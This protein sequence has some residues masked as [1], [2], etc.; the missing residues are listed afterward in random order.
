MRL[1]GSYSGYSRSEM[2][3]ARANR[4]ACGLDL[5]VSHRPARRVQ[6]VAYTDRQAGSQS[7]FRLRRYATQLWRLA[8][9]HMNIHPRAGRRIAD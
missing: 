3:W 1:S 6:R 4:P 9:D 7:T 5:T 2:R 8:G